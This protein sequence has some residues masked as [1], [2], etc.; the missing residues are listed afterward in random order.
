MNYNQFLNM[1]Q[2]DADVL[3]GT[4]TAIM[5]SRL[6][7]WSWGRRRSVQSVLVPQFRISSQL[8]VTS[9]ITDVKG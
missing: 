7:V 9:R 5:F 2:G 1:Q 3:V 8:S 4:Y 6:C